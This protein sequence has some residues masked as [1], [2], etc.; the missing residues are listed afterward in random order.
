VIFESKLKKKI[1][2]KI[3][4]TYISICKIRYNQKKLVV[5]PQRRF[6][7]SD[8]LKRNGHAEGRYTTDART[9]V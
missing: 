7:T 4:Q 5:G 2:G 9:A 3:F 8:W 6:L 1:I